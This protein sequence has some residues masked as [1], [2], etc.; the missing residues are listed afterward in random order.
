MSYA[1]LGAEYRASLDGRS[2][3]DVLAERAKLERARRAAKA[4]GYTAESADAIPADPGD[5]ST[6]TADDGDL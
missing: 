4:A 1:D 5:R 6:W 3:A 2:L